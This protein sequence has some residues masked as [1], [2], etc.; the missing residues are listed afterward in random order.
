MNVESSAKRRA[1]VLTWFCDSPPPLKSSHRG[2]AFATIPPDIMKR[3]QKN[4]FVNMWF[5]FLEITIEI[6]KTT[7]PQVY[8]SDKGKSAWSRC[9]RIL[10]DCSPSAWITCMY[11]CAEHNRVTRPELCSHFKFAEKQ[12]EGGRR[13][14]VQMGCK[15]KQDPVSCFRSTS[16]NSRVNRKI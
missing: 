1:L 7:F 12:E 14:W 16:C 8:F 13:D 10:T 11:K 4:K 5:T 6:F 3:H 2:I 9:D 15:L